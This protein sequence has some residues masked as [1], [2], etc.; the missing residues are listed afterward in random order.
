[1]N[2]HVRN[3]YYVP[4]GRKVGLLQGKDTESVRVR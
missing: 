1:M 4:V 3:V 2:L